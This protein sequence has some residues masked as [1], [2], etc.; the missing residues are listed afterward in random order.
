M[1]NADFSHFLQ[2][3]CW[4]IA[5]LLLVLSD[6]GGIAAAG[7]I[8]GFAADYADEQY[9]KDIYDIIS[10]FTDA[11]LLMISWKN[12]FEVITGSIFDSKFKDM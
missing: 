2:V 10:G 3:C 7:D 8:Y 4:F 12:Y 1:K 11:W 5:D 9:R 6:I